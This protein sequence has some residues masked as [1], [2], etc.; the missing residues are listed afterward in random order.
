MRKHY[1][2]NLRWLD[3]LMLIPY[4]AAMAWNT[5]D[6]PNYIR[7]ESSRP[8]A[9]LITAFSPFFMP[10]LFLLAGMSTRYALKKR[11]YGQYIKERAKRLLVPLVFGTLAFMPVMTW[12]ADRF[13]NGCTDSFFEHY[14][15]FFTKFTDLTGADGGFSLGQFWFLLYLFVISLIAVG[16]IALQ[17]KY[18][19]GTSKSLPFPAVILL[20][21]PLPLLA[22]LLSVGGKSVAEFLYLF[23]IG[24]YV[25]SDDSVT[26]KAAKYCPLTLSIGICASIA[27]VYLFIWSGEEFKVLNTVTNYLAG[28]FMLLG[29]I[30]LGKRRLDFTGKLSGLM[31]KISFPFYG[32][33]FIW[34]VLFQYLLADPLSGS[35][36]LLFA[37]PIA[38]A[39]ICTFICCFI[40]RRI[41]PL[42]F[43]MGTK[44][45]RR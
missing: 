18:I 15:V 30:G 27:N 24:C 43:L 37:V 20:G 11:S 25:F 6:E 12:L 21:L 38:A 32:F 10:L 5:W 29:L 3:I 7:F 1:I 28:W 31:T 26:D 23:L 14:A 39:Y 2:D 16:I 17:R 4:H 42:A 19:K 41:P 35:T 40:C 33:H 22:E 13:N 8:I 45:D 9:S 36:A 34:V 44:A